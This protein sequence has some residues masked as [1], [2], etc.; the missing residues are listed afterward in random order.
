[1]VHVPVVRMALSPLQDHYVFF[2]LGWG[3]APQFFNSGPSGFAA[4]RLI[5]RRRGNIRG[6]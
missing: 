1:M 4:Q 3:L 2:S 5:E 6:C